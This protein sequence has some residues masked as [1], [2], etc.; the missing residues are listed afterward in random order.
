MRRKLPELTDALGLCSAAVTADRSDGNAAGRMAA[1]VLSWR[2]TDILCSAGPYAS[3]QVAPALQLCSSR[4]LHALR[5]PSSMQVS[6]D[7]GAGL[8]HRY[9]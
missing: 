5:R 4:K 3:L 2:G 1:G 9:C 7:A 6:T 8:S